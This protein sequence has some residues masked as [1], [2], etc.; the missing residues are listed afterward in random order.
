MASGVFS[1][2]RDAGYDSHSGVMKIYIDGKDYCD[3]QEQCWIWSIGENV[4]SGQIRASTTTKFYQAPG[5]KCLW[6]R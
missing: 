4:N 2:A 3:A 6:L 5:W 1:H